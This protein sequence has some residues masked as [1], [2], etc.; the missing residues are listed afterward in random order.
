MPADERK[1]GVDDVRGGE[2]QTVWDGA[3]QLAE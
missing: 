3:R 1:Q 2:T